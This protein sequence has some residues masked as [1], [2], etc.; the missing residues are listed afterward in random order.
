MD[1]GKIFASVFIGIITIYLA[2]VL[3]NTFSEITPE[4]AG[5]GGLLFIV[6]FIV[7]ILGIIGLFRSLIWT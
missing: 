6:I 3:I 1:I 2:Y 4:F 5:F 7:I